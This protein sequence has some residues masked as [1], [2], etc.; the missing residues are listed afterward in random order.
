MKG[1]LAN[2][3]FAEFQKQLGEAL[4][5]LRPVTDLVLPGVARLYGCETGQGLNVYVQAQVHRSEDSFT[6]EIAWNRRRDLWPIPF[7]V[8]PPDP[9]AAAGREGGRFRLCQLWV[10]RDLW[11]D[12][13]SPAAAGAQVKD[14]VSHL[15]QEGWPYLTGVAA[16]LGV[17]LAPAG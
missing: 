15:K 7:L 16:R 12:V 5:A 13:K 1:T 4:P 2:A 8:S 6:V 9:D 11:W 3:V 17:V 14:A 10:S